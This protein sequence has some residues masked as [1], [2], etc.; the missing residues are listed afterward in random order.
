MY[1]TCTCCNIFA[2]SAVHVLGLTATICI[3]YVHVVYSVYTVSSTS[4]TQSWSSLRAKSYN[5]HE[6]TH[7]PAS[8]L[9]VFSLFCGQTG[10]FI[11]IVIIHYSHLLMGK[12]VRVM[13]NQTTPTRFIVSH[14]T[15]CVMGNYE[16]YWSR[17]WSTVI[18]NPQ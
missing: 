7:L 10:L 14:Y 17:T 8:A 16:S 13:N 18:D 15:A 3:I 4:P 1:Y 11:F 5:E 6:Q 2:V 12:T 9:P